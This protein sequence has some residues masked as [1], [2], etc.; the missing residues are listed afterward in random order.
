MK[1]TIYHVRAAAEPF[2]L[3]PNGNSVM[4]VVTDGYPRYPI[5]CIPVV[6]DIPPY[7]NLLDPARA[8]EFQRPADALLWIVEQI[9][10]CGY[11]ENARTIA[12]AHGITLCANGSYYASRGGNHNA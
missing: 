3:L 1:I 9:F 2:E 4:H 8:V 11:Q 6:K 12:D 10:R 5:R 7:G